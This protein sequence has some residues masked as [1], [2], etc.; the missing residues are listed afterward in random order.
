MPTDPTFPHEQDPLTGIPARNAIELYGA[1]VPVQRHLREHHI[2]CM[3]VLIVRLELRSARPT[4]FPKFHVPA[5]EVRD[6]QGK[7]VA[8]VSADVHSGNF[9][10]SVPSKQS[11]P[12]VVP[13]ETPEAIAPLIPGGEL[14]AS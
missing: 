6:R 1:L 10:V 14:E 7:V 13:A 4:S 12:Y 5:L 2:P 3:R 9:S 8:T 11:E